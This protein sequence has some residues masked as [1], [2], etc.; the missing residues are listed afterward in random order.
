MFYYNIILKS[1]TSSWWLIINF[2]MDAVQ[3]AIKY[4]YFIEGICC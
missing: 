2:Q 1:V 4:L 3:I